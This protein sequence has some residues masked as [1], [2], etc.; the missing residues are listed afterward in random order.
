MSAY[1]RQSS[2]QGASACPESH[3]KGIA[4]EYYFSQG[5]IVGGTSYYHVRDKLRSV[6]ER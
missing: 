2:G 6:R 4:G 1:P 5:V 3:A